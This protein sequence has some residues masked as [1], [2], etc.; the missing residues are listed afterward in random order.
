MSKR[1]GYGPKLWGHILKHQL[2]VQEAEFW[3]CVRDAIPPRRGE[4]P[5]PPRESIPA[6]VVAALLD[7]GCPR[8]R[9]AD[10]DEGRGR[11]EDGRALR[12]TE[13]TQGGSRGPR[14][15]VGTGAHGSLPSAGARLRT[16]GRV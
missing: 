16:A 5:P 1:D 11:H 13:L 14:C 7:L 2:E 6:G 3:D 9:S 12:R 10:H 4:E 8:A 15:P